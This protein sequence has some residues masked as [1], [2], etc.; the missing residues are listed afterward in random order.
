MST[1]SH[2][3][4]QV[5]TILNQYIPNEQ[6]IAIAVSGGCDSMCLLSNIKKYWKENHRDSSFLHILS[7][8]HNTRENNQKE[9]D[10]VKQ[11]SKWSPMNVFIYQWNSYTE[12][13]L[14]ERRHQ[15]FADYCQTK[16]IKIL[17]LGHHLDDRIETTLLNMYRGAWLQ[18]ISSISASD[19]YFLD[20]SINVL[21]PLITNTKQ[22]ILHYC[23]EKNI[24]FAHDPTNDDPEYSKRNELR[25]FLKDA[26][27]SDARYKSFWMLYETLQNNKTQDIKIKDYEELS[28]LPQSGHDLITLRSGERTAD[29]L[30]K[31]YQ[32]YAISINPRTTTLTTL[33]NQL[34]KKSGNKISYQWLTI[35]AYSYAS[36]VKNCK[37]LAI[38][39]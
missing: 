8:N 4:Q 14:R 29:T 18:G 33:S 38:V 11:V 21:R 25:I 39:E 20:S 28:I 15:C 24:A 9:I 32:Y 35:V 10:L 17:V 36:V 31:L 5:K 3:E 19:S 2:L 23:Q 7:C 16:N 12:A 22:D 6:N 27:N 34:N 37:T 13:S 1:S 26:L 30:Y